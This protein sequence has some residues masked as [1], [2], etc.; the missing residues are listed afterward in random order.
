MASSPLLQPAPLRPRQQLGRALLVSGGYAL[1]GAWLL[2]GLH[3]CPTAAVLHVPCPGCG[4]TRAT[5]AALGGDWSQAFSL[6]PLFWLLS[7]LFVFLLSVVGLSYIRGRSV[8]PF[9]GRVSPVW[10]TAFGVALSLLTT[11]V[12][13]ARFYG[14]FGGPVP[15]G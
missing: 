15:V 9:L 11:G 10:V 12:W 2:S 1:L 5:L 13:L 4:L 7:P 6:H 3:T 8:A 14:A